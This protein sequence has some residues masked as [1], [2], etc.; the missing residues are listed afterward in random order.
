MKDGRDSKQNLGE[1]SHRDPGATV[2]GHRLG[3]LSIWSEEHLPVCCI[4]GRRSPVPPASGKGSQKRKQGLHR[5]YYNQLGLKLSMNPHPGLET[6]CTL[7]AS[8]EQ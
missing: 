7:S 6:R 3:H 5:I 4:H 1:H 8:S 2:S